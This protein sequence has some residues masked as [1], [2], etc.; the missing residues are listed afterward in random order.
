[1]RSKLERVEVDLAAEAWASLAAQKKETEELQAGLLAQRKEIEVDLQ[2][3][4]RS[5]CMSIKGV[6][7]MYFFCYRCCMKKNGIMHDI[8]SL[9]SNDEDAIPGGPPQ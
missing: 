5:Y 4:R 7:K 8:P 6:D 2:L 1:M 3:V 9:P